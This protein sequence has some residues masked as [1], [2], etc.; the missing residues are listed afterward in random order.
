MSPFT[1]S[2]VF[3]LQL[4]QA[5]GWYVS[6]AYAARAAERYFKLPAGILMKVCMPESRC[7]RNKIGHN[8]NKTMDVSPWQVNVP[9]SDINPHLALKY[10]NMFIAAHRAGELLAWSRS[11]CRKEKHP[12]CKISEYIFYNFNSPRWAH[13][14]FHKG[15]NK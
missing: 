1:P 3:L 14:V 12:R 10:R 5:L 15:E 4:L 6:P 7:Q 9:G 8:K 11:K 13:K 2:L